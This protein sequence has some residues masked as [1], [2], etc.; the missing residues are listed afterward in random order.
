[1]GLTLKSLTIIY[2]KAWMRMGECWGKK[3]KN[4]FLSKNT[5]IN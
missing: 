5:L 4:R 3:K 2:L 1:M